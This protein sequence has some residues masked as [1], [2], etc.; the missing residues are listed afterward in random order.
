MGTGTNLFVILFVLS[1]GMNLIN[2]TEWG[3]PMFEYITMNSLTGEVNFEP[4]KEKVLSMFTLSIAAGV[5]ASLFKQDM[6]F[7]II[8]SIVV[9]LMGMSL[10]PINLFYN[11]NIP[12]FIKLLVGG[13][14]VL[15]Y[16]FALI[17]F[18]GGWDL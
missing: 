10:M 5:V 16:I 2:P 9:F 4:F 15:M 14:M 8:A 12:F 6:R 1:M 3:S 7:G 17:S 11:T 18:F 13:P